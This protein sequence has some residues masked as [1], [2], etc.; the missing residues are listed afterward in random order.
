VDFETIQDF[1]N[2]ITD[3]KRRGDL[4]GARNFLEQTVAYFERVYS[5]EDGIPAW[6]YEQLS[7]VLKKQGFKEEA[8]RIKQKYD[9]TVINNHAVETKRIAKLPDDIRLKYHPNGPVITKKTVNSAK[10]LMKTNPELVK[11]A[12]L[13]D[14][15]NNLAAPSPT[16]YDLDRQKDSQSTDRSS[17]GE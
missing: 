3:L 10:R 11:A 17:K 5:R 4:A 7:V 12:G 1:T 9:E 16:Q 6:Y 13:L 15:N 8:A 2:F 14:H